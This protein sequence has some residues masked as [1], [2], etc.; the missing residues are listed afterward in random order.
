MEPAR[1]GLWA[2]AP[3]PFIFA[4]RAALE[5][6][7]REPSQAPGLGAVTAVG[8]VLSLAG[9]ALM[10]WRRAEAWP[11]ALLVLSGHFVVSPWL[12]GLGAGMVY[13]GTGLLT[14]PWR[15]WA[16]AGGALAL[17]SAPFRPAAAAHVG[18]AVGAFVLGIG[19]VQAA[20]D[21]RRSS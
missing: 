7:G 4:L 6:L 16:L 18:V 5:T 10:L 21:M 12:P 11:G 3:A 17:L 2:L 13:L 20:L 15:P 14:A 9:V 8:G 19:I 1:W